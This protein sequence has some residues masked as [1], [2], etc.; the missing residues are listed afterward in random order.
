MIPTIDKP[1]LVRNNSATLIDNIFAN[2]EEV[3]VSGNLMSDVS[4]HFS[5]F[6][7]IKSVREK[8]MKFH[9]TKIRD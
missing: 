9:K 5:Q 1:T 7:T 3:K 2:S 6:C 4:D 8:P